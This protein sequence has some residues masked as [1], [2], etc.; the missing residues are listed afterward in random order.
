MM[1][2]T[3][4]FS[5]FHKETDWSP[6]SNLYCREKCKLYFL[7]VV[8]TMSCGSQWIMPNMSPQTQFV[9]AAKLSLLQYIACTI[10]IIEKIMIDPLEPRSK[11]HLPVLE[12]FLLLVNTATISY[13][14][15]RHGHEQCRSKIKKSKKTQSQLSKGASKLI[16]SSKVIG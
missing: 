13:I 5:A 11:V 2:H 10:R 7:R 4:W 12:Y 16:S 3:F 9:I 8:C 1:T 15:D 6:V 14:A